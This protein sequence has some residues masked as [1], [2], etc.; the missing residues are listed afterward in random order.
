MPSKLYI[1]KTSVETEP[2]R[3]KNQW[4]STENHFCDVGLRLK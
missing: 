4:L 3:R 2:L 1:I